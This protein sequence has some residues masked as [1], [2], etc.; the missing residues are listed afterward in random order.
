MVKE[1]INSSSENSDNLYE[2]REL[3][4]YN[5]DYNTFEFVIKTLIDVCKQ[6]PEQAEQCALVTHFKGKCSIRI[7][8]TIELTP[9]CKELK[10]RGLTSAIE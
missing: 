6:E 1:K 10:N 4:L 3:V 2:I 7:G 5:D 9:I 8:E